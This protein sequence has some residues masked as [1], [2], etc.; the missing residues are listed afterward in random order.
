MIILN[1][2]LIDSVVKEIIMIQIVFINVN[3]II[4]T[5]ATQKRNQSGYDRVQ[6]P[7][8]LPQTSITTW[9]TN[10]HCTLKSSDLQ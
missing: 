10:S 8:W 1:I 9:L 7:I 5:F 4:T 2:Y 6:R 3:V